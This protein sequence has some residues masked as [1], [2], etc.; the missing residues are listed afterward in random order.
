MLSMSTYNDELFTDPRYDFFLDKKLEQL[1]K[2][3]WNYTQKPTSDGSR[4][5]VVYS[6]GDMESFT[7][8]KDG[9]LERYTNHSDGRELERTALDEDTI[10][11]LYLED[12]NEYV[13][14]FDNLEEG[15]ELL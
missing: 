5:T 10:T 11:F 7:Y 4:I 14:H 1:T 8:D 13:F 12:Y 15:G 6:D 9:I 2:E 3:G